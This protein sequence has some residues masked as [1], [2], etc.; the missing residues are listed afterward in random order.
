MVRL[1]QHIRGAPSQKYASKARQL[2]AAK[3]LQTA[4]EAWARS[5]ALAVDA[6]R[7]RAA[8]R[9]REQEND[10]SQKLA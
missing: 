8:D 4:A 7:Q 10:F 9:E 6:Y 2:E 1:G 5:N 3:E